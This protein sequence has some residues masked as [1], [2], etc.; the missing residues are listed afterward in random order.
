MKKL[1]KYIYMAHSTTFDFI[2]KKKKCHQFLIYDL[3][4][5]IYYFIDIEW[6]L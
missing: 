3:E 1:L 5:K 2:Y 4:F 6:I